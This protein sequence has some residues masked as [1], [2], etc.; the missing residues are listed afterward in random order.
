MTAL[1]ALC[2]QAVGGKNGAV[3]QFFLNLAEEMDAQLAPDVAMCCSV[4]LDKQKDLPQQTRKMLQSLG[5]HLGEFDLYG[6][7]GC[8]KSVKAEIERQL[9]LHCKNKDVRIRSYQTLGLCAGAALAI[10]FI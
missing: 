9:E 6:Q 5:E 10:L 2:R 1:P 3:Y 4:C 7:V 8:L